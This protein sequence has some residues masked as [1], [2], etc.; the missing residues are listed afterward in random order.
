[1]LNRNR[2]TDFP[3]VALFAVALQIP[4]H[5][6]QVV[7]TVTGSIY[8]GKDVSGV[9][10][11]PNSDLN[12]SGI[13]V[14]YT[15]DESIGN[16]VTKFCGKSP[17]GS[18]LTA[19]GITSPGSVVIQVNGGST[20]F[21]NFFNIQVARTIA[22]AI[23]SLYFHAGDGGYN[24]ATVYVTP[25]VATT[26]W[27]T[28]Y[29]WQDA[30]SYSGPFTSQAGFVVYKSSPHQY[31]FGEFTVGTVSISGA[32]ACPAGNFDPPTA[33]GGTPHFYVVKDAICS[34][35]NPTCT[36]K[37]VFTALEFFPSDVFREANPANTCDVT[38]TPLGPVIHYV[39]P[40]D[41]S[42]TNV[43]LQGHRLYPGQVIRSVIDVNG[44]VYIQTTGTGTGP[45]PWPW[46]NETAAGAY[47]GSVDALIGAFFQ[48]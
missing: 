3:V 28:D 37:L 16:E 36:P 27:T 19:F 24:A 29:R 32:L 38:D 31:A 21:Q 43:T 13:T 12:G 25:A 39:D 6:S 44:T 9:F 1:M 5:A 11:A 2:L 10:G 15:F 20:F 47:W 26:S 17:C 4:A 8:S 48:P 40:S 33:R 23:H 35:S 42:V 22:P 45:W 7:V 41:L 34:T 18:S 30:F 14:T 46:A